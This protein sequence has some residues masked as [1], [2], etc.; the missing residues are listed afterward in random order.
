MPSLLPIDFASELMEAS[1]FL[2]ACPSAFLL[3]FF[4]KRPTLFPMSSPDLDPEVEASLVDFGK[5]SRKL[6]RMIKNNRI[7]VRSIMPHA[8]QLFLFLSLFPFPFSV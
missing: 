3:F 4:F 1:T 7:Q 8:I 6:T 2:P 5:N